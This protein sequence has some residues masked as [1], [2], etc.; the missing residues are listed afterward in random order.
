MKSI[1]KYDNTMA[2]SLM[3]MCPDERSLLASFAEKNSNRYTIIYKDGFFKSK[4]CCNKTPTGICKERP[5]K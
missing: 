2:S 4:R 3:K 5:V 1:Y